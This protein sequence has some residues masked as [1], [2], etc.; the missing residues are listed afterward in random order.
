MIQKILNIIILAPPIMIAIILHEVAHG[1]VANRLGDPTARN[2]GRLTLNP[3][4]HIDLFGT[5]LLPLT[6]YLMTHNNPSGPLIFGYAKP[7]PINPAYFRDP[8]KGLALSSVAGP[9]VNVIMALA[10][11]F[12]FHAGLPVL[13]WILP[14]SLMVIA[15]MMLAYGVVI[16]VVLAVLNMIP[17]PPL[18][19][20]RV[21]LWL[22]PPR[23]AMAYNQLERYG[24][25]ILLALFATG[26]LNWIVHPLVRPLIRLLLGDLM[27]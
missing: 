2:A 4:P 8:R 5:V 15:Q 11:A 22:L 12:I 19:G 10:C 26:A 7:V 9:G 6:M 23:Q 18:D 3:I 17:I 13:S 20:S 27:S 16:N 21:V 24:M 14:K 25:F 1:W